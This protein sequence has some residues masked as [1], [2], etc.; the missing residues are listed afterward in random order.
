[1]GQRSPCL[2][3]APASDPWRNR[4]SYCVTVDLQGADLP[5][6]ETVSDRAED[7]ANLRTHQD[8]NGDHDNRNE[9]DNQRVL[10]QTLALFLF[11]HGQLHHK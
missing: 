6:L 2:P 7:V 1:M 8:Q 9:C 4:Y 11:P 3:F 10:H 5:A